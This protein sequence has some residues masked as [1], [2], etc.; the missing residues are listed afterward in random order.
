M[1]TG[2]IEALGTVLEVTENGTN[3]N[4]W[5]GSPLSETLKIDQSLSHDGVCLTIEGIE[6]HAYRVTAVQETLVK[7]NLTQWTKNRIVNLE[8]CLKMNGRIDGHLVQGHVDG[9]GICLDKQ[10]LKGS[11]L[12]RLGFPAHFAPL[13]IEKGSICINGISL[14][15]FDVTHDQFSVAIIPYTYANTNMQYLEPGQSVNLE[16][17][18]IGKYVLRQSQFKMQSNLSAEAV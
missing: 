9:M 16:F 18:L 15:A 7:T 10:D 3:R 14:T 8:R 1:F 6:S 2:I 17:D 11:W 4:F 5:I 13:L 12:I